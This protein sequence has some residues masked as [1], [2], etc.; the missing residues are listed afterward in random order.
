MDN[1]LGEF[2]GTLVLIVFGCGV[3]GLNAYASVDIHMN[4]GEIYECSMY[5]AVISDCDGT[6]FNNVTIR[7]CGYNSIQTQRCRVK[8]SGTTYYSPDYSPKDYWD[9]DYY[10]DYYGDE[11]NYDDYGFAEEA[12][13]QPFINIPGAVDLGESMDPVVEGDI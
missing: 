2:M 12:T 3:N 8:F 7:D 5:A 6:E 13:Y 9:D 10:D 4:D 1:L 11:V